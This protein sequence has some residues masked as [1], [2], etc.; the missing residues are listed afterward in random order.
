MRKPLDDLSK[1]LA[2]ETRAKTRIAIEE[3]FETID[4]SSPVMADLL[5]GNEVEIVISPIHIQLREV[6]KGSAFTGPKA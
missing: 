3:V 2:R 5:A 6:N 1:E 4:D